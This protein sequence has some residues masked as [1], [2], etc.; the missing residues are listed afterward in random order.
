MPGSYKIKAKHQ[1]M[2]SETVIID[3]TA[4]TVKIVDLLGKFQIS[5]Q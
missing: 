4:N 2:E 1:N 3:V 5:F